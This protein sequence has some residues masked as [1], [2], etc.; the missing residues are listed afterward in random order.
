[1]EKASPLEVKAAKLLIVNDKVVLVHKKNNCF[2]KPRVHTL[3]HGLMN[4]RASRI[5][6]KLRLQG[7]WTFERRAQER[8]P[9]PD[10]RN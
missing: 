1:M 2:M 6:Y 10:N 9:W 5:A 4:R 3:T 8:C 7:S